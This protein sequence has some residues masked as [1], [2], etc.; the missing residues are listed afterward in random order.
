MSR[1]SFNFQELK[2]KMRHKSPILGSYQ[3]Q[4]CTIYGEF[5]DFAHKKIRPGMNPGPNLINLL[6]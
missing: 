6:L 2:E 5:N 3:K 4:Y 1:K